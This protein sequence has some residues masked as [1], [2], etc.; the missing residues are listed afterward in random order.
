[1]NSPYM[2]APGRFV[3]FRV[4]EGKTYILAD[5]I[6]RLAGYQQNT[7]GAVSA[8]R[9]DTGVGLTSPKTFL[10]YEGSQRLFWGMSAFLDFRN[11][12]QDSKTLPSIIYDKLCL[13]YRQAAA[14]HVAEPVEDTKREVVRA[15]LL[16]GVLHIKYNDNSPAKATTAFV[17]DGEDYVVKIKKKGYPT[18][19]INKQTVKT[20]GE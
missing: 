20:I 1:M 11:R 10:F 4:Y 16:D 13:L 8:I 9:I 18:V 17:I 3:H 14:M 7:S 19:R 2:I 6:A 5:D 15:Y 12:S